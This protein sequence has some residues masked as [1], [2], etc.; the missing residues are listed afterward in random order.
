MPLGIFPVL[1]LLL[2]CVLFILAATERNGRGT[3]DRQR[4]LSAG[5]ACWVLYILLQLI[6]GLV[7]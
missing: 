3:E 6:G 4:L 1:L 2:A 7:K 5:L